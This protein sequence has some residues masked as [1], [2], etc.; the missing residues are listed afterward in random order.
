MREVVS[1]EVDLVDGLVA[2]VP[3]VVGA[4]RRLE[5][6]PKLERDLHPRPHLPREHHTVE[7][8]LVRE[9]DDLVLVAGVR[10]GL[11]GHPRAA[12]VE[13]VVKVPL[14]QRISSTE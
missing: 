12:V 13:V 1:P 6:D 2:L 14:K 10:K 3:G 9:F 4:E 8:I 5:E 7:V 11:V